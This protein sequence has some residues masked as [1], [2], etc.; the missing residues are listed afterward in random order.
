MHLGGGGHRNAA[1]PCRE[2]R[3]HDRFEQLLRRYQA[4]VFRVAQHITRW[5]VDAEEVTQVAFLKAFQNLQRFEGRSRFP[6]G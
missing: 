6:L 3:R 5:R 4:M 1:G 2:E